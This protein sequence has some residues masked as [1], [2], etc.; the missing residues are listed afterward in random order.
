MNAVYLSGT[1][2]TKHIVSLL[3]NELGVKG[4]LFPIESDDVMMAFEDDV[5]RNL[6]PVVETFRTGPSLSFLPIVSVPSLLMPLP[7]CP[8]IVMEIVPPCKSILP[9]EVRPLAV[10]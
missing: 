9:S 6:A 7:P 4:S 10:E 2:N 5:L 1:G 3:V 8:D